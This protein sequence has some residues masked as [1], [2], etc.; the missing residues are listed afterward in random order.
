[1]HLQQP[2]PK[3]RMQTSTVTLLVISALLWGNIEGKTKTETLKLLLS[4]HTILAASQKHPAAFQIQIL[5]NWGLA[6]AWD[7]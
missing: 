7:L 1:M 5:V 4:W 6:A 3:T 2:N